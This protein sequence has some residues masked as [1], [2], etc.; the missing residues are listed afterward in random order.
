MS[1]PSTPLSLPNP[2][3]CIPQTPFQSS[4]AQRKRKTE[5]K[6]IKWTVTAFCLGKKL[7]WP[8][9]IQYKHCGCFVCRKGHKCNLAKQ[10][11][12]HPNNNNKQENNPSESVLFCIHFQACME[13]TTTGIQAL[14]PCPVKGP[15]LEA[16]RNVLGPTLEADSPFQALPTRDW[17]RTIISLEMKQ[18][19]KMWLT[20][21]AGTSRCL[22]RQVSSTSPGE[23][24]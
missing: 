19:R 23:H 6:E 16:E 7:L 10:S 18:S 5:N 1:S 21:R 17:K 9:S 2:L 14:E 8:K 12:P 15:P 13:L 11:L 24:N 3:G 22:R 20:A 4:G